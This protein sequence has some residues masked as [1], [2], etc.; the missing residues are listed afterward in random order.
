MVKRS[1]WATLNAVILTGLL[2]V[3]IAVWAPARIGSPR[4]APSLTP[5]VVWKPVTLG[6]AILLAD[7]SGRE[8]WSG[9]ETRGTSPLY[10]R[11]PDGYSLEI[12]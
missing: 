5:S 10:V 7:Y 11:C 4:V 8:D 1:M 2:M 3:A 9:C 6:M 12:R